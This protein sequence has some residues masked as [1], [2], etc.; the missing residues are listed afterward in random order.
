MRV[1]ALHNRKPIVI[2]L[3]R[4]YSTGLGVVRSLGVAGYT[5]DLIAS[6]K[7]RGSSAIIASSKYVRKCVEVLSPK[8]QTDN[9][10]ELI[11]E[12]LRYSSNTDCKPVLFPTDDF[13]TTVMAANYERLKEHF[14][15]PCVS[16]SGAASLLVAMNKAYQTELAKSVGMLTPDECEVS[17]RGD[18]E[19]PDCISYPCFVKPLSSVSG[20]K[21]EMK[22]CSDK[23]ELLSHLEDIKKYYSDRS[24]LIQE[25]LDIDKEYDLSG[26]CINDDIIIP[27]IVEK[28]NISD[29][30]RGVT[31]T[32]RT[33]PCSTLGNELD[34]IKSML[35]S[36]G[37]HGMFDMELN[38]CGERIY[39]NEIN[40]RSGG[41]NYSY[42]LN[43]V[44]L[45]DIFVKS[46][47][48]QA[49][50]SNEET[51][52]EYGKTFVYEKIAWEDYIHNNISRSEL[53]HC[54]KDA[55]YT[56]LADKNDPAPG[57]IFC[58]KIRLSAIKHRLL[59]FLGKEK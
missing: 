21:A 4:N 59:I 35:K 46:L 29:F 31:M 37:Y 22:K 57:R 15:M 10:D 5:V 51:V 54:I 12:I 28:I 6:T 53:K 16:G 13:T 19:L 49:H 11:D 3:S 43:G 44:N 52:A 25:Y 41:P 56:L 18:I 8:I 36:L 47:I 30:E 34:K 9:G 1:I 32:G 17:L 2:V 38:L 58:K 24:V 50:T 33:L 20:R 14:L 45:P 26:V 40:L 7:K 55:D 23:K 48:G 27:A 42:L 39:F